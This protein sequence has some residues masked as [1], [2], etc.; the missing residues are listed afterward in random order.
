MKLLLVSANREHSPY[1][2]F[3][4]GLAFLVPKLE[5]AGH[6]VEGLDLCFSDNPMADLHAALER[7]K[8]DVSIISM[9]N[10]DNVAYPGVRSYVDGVKEVVTL[11]K[12]YGKTIIGGSGF[13]IF[14]V[15]LMEIFGADYGNVGEGEDLLPELLAIVE[16]GELP[17]GLPGVIIQGEKN[18]RPIKRVSDIGTP[19]RR[20]FDVG[21]YNKKGG[22]A[23]LQTKRG[24]PFSCTYC[25][26][27]MLEGANIRTRPV[28]DIVKEIQ[29]LVNDYGVDYIYFVDDIFNF[30]TE[31]AGGLCRKIVEEK[32]HVNWSAFIN[33]DFLPPKLL[34]EMLAA[35]CDAVEFGT[36]AGSPKMLKSLGKS[37]SVD[38][39]INGSALCKERGMDFAHY[40]L[41]GG[42]GESEET[43][44]ETFR[45]M[46]EVEP[47][48]VI[49][50]TGIRIFPNT[51]L[52]KQAILEGV[53]KADDSLVEPTFYISPQIA[54]RLCDFVTSE[55]LKRKNWI[56]PGLEV[57]ISD[58]MLE[59]IRHFP[60]RGPLWKLIKRMGRSRVRPV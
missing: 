46:D 10:V 51:G 13:S 40:I 21:L 2:V 29:H 8:P 50:M 20:L 18:F 49:A 39:I 33:P 36:E 55:A 12:K 34:D 44:L 35:G 19:D 41:F 1:P 7:Y 38:S 27:P 9:R 54:D 14:P 47:T 37:F 22:M 30:P 59:M 15:Q 32:L 48:A 24:C 31:F 43:I 6:Q 53:I 52:H 11:C 58:A 57:N 56:A 60:V 25:T 17:V 28:E 45:L 16:N 5:E 42:P 3:P 4:I 26:Y 23:N